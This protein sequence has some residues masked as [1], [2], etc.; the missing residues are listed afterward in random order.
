MPERRV[1]T[2]STVAV[3]TASYAQWERAA[4][5]ADLK[6]RIKKDGVFAQWYQGSSTHSRKGKIFMSTAERQG[7]PS[8]RRPDVISRAHNR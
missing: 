6:E 4:S 8:M 7:V 5:V 2:S 3:Q 1:D